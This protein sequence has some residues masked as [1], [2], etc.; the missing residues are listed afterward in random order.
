MDIK[1]IEHLAE[2]SKLEFSTEELEE[3]SNEFSSLLEL[4]DMVKNAEISGSS[5][6]NSTDMLN[7]REDKAKDSMPVD[8]LLENTPVVKKDCIVVP[9]IME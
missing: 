3:F 8:I 4:A 6:V 7:L 9:R 1:E 5:F 2:L